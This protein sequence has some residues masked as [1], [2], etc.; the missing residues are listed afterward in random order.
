MHFDFSSFINMS[1]ILLTY[2]LSISIYLSPLFSVS[3]SLLVTKPYINV[4][5]MGC[6]LS[7]T[8][9]CYLV[10]FKFNNS[11]V[12]TSGGKYQITNT[13]FPVILRLL[14]VG[15]SDAGTYQCK[16]KCSGVDVSSS[17]VYLPYA[18]KSM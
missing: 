7:D 17:A 10:N 16:F 18:C 4:Q 11:I 5:Y 6:N 1:L 15:P 13:S 14:S 8:T 3:V 9:N 12:N 2:S